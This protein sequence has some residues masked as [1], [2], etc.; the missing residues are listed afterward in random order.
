MTDQEKRDSI[1]AVAAWLDGKAVQARQRSG[2]NWYDLINEPE[3]L[4]ETQCYRPKP[5]PRLRPWRH[6]EVPMP[7]VVRFK[8]SK[9]RQNIAYVPENGVVLSYSGSLTLKE[10]LA[11]YEQQDGSP[12]GVSEV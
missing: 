4:F 1:A 7:C 3:W 8:G 11:D 6:D 9:L 2:S 10:L 5:T 12:C